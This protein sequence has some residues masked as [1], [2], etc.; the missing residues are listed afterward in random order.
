MNLLL[1]LL[2]LVLLQ[3]ETK[4][5]MQSHRI[6][7]DVSLTADP[8]QPAW[9][10]VKG[11]VTSIDPFGKP[12]PNARTEIRSVWSDRYLYF[13]F[14]SQ[15]ERLYLQKPATPHKETWG[16][17]EY[18][19]VEVFIGWDAERIHLYKEFE[20]SPQGEWVDLDVDNN[21]PPK[22]TVNWLWN[23]GFEFKTRIDE[24][25]KVWFCEMRIPWKSID[26]RTPAA[27]NELRL[28][29]YRIE[30]GPPDRRYIVWSPI[31]N[32][33]FHTPK[34]FGTLRLSK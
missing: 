34:G 4:P 10:N 6:Q 3:A 29:L 26:P 1:M 15:Y 8:N 14:V 25:N 5:V 32:P 12:L 20:V 30:G 24:K 23:S 21:K 27:G 9:K 11:V 18:D 7:G 17:W 16:L 13:F 33:S 28:N 2:P 22:Q 31:H 19:V